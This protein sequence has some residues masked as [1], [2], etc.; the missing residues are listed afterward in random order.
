MDAQTLSSDEDI[1][2]TKGERRRA[3]II[4]LGR[5]LLIEEG[6]DAF[7]LRTVA[8]QAEITLGNLQYYFPVREDL[9]EA[10]GN[11]EFARGL[12]IV[13]S[14]HRGSGTPEEKLAEMVRGLVGEWHHTGGRVYAVIAMLALHQER[15]RHLHAHQYRCFYQAVAEL[16]KAINTKATDK[17]AL[18]QARLITSM[19]DGSLFQVA[20]EGK[21]SRAER[22]KFDEE[23]VAAILKAVTP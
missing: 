15:F 5:N 14:A 1:K 22:K 18:R 4:S 11:E 9:L 23:I 16:L 2:L 3:E 20:L 10:I 17:E 6:Y 8:A 7:V 12:D 13:Q 21:G 19:M